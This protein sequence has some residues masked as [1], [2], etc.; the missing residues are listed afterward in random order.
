[1]KG[2]VFT[3]GMVVLVFGLAFV[4][5]DNGSSP[6][7]DDIVV[8][9]SSL[10]PEMAYTVYAANAINSAFWQWSGDYRPRLES[11]LKD[12]GFT[13][14]SSEENNMADG[15]PDGE[16]LMWSPYSRIE[17]T[18]GAKILFIGFVNGPEGKDY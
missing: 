16:Y 3:L 12:M 9:P 17:Y 8:D 6:D 15:N 14:I 18:Y 4:G 13:E 11:Y 7:N 5:C 2:K 10:S 1:M